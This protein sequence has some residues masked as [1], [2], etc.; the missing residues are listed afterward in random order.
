M[1]I[2]VLAF[3]LVFSVE[4]DRRGGD[5]EVGLLVVMQDPLNGS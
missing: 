5:G 2:L 3:L 4:T 1:Q